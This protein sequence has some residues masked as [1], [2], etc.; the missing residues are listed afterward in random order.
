MTLPEERILA[1]H[2]TRKFLQSL[3]DP[4][5]TPRV[6]GPIRKRAY[7]LLRHYP[8]DHDVKPAIMDK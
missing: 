7:W 1:I 8:R 5:L 3:L 6:P 4:K 2:E